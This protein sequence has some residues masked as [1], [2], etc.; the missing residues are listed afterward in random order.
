[1]EEKFVPIEFAPGY[2]V[3]NFGRIKKASG[4]IMSTPTT[5]KGYCIF[6]YTLN[7]KRYQ[8]LLHRIVAKHFI[9][10]IEGMEINHKDFNKTNNHIDNL[11]IVTRAQ[12]AAHYK[13]SEVA[14][15]AGEKIRKIKTKYTPEEKR[16]I[17][18]KQK[19]YVKKETPHGGRRPNS[20]RKPATE[21]DPVD[22]KRPFYLRRSQV[23]TGITG[24]QVRE[25]V[26]LFLQKKEA[27][28]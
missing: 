27:S 19:R 5:T 25:A 20:G 21:K 13:G 23:E 2:L 16:E 3:S 11:E 6:S 4:K 10:D 14:R 22:K 7:G 17:R 8:S 15:L 26:D 24:E 12:N 1:M 18:K 28:P 9:G